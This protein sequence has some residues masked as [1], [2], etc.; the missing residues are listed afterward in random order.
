M[1]RGGI[2]VTG[3][4]APLSRQGNAFTR[5]LRGFA[6]Y[7]KYMALTLM[8]LPVVVYFFIFKYI[9]MGGIVIA[10]KNYK[11]KEGI[12]G[13]AWCGLDNF[14]KAFATPT[15]ARSV[16]NTLIISGLKLLYGFPAPII[17][18]LMLNEVTHVRFKKTVQTISYLPHFLSWVVLAGMFQQLLSPSNGAVNAVLK[19]YFGLKESIY[20]LGSNQYFRGTLIVTD[21]WKNVGWSSILYLATISGI[22]PALYEAATVDGASRWQC[23]RYITIPSLVSTIV[24]MLILSIGSIMDAGFDQVFNLY[25]SAVYQT[26]DI[27]DTYVYRYG[28]GDMK[29]S[30]ATAVGLFKNVIAF[31]LVVG[32]NLIT[33]RISGEGIW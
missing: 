9:P 7:K 26:G 17:L 32:T 30:L 1:D 29:Y 5:W 33:R 14:T 12:F 16:Q 19:Q 6:G 28:L 11:I 31:V 2:N 18:A 4:G 15:F 27:I 20:F 13:S 10:F 22:D 23:T 25:N 8:F 3:I 24:V 21:I